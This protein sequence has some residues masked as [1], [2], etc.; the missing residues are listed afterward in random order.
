MPKPISK[1]AKLNPQDVLN[2][3]AEYTNLQY[4]AMNK[5]GTWY[6]FTKQPANLT[7]SQGWYSP[8]SNIKLKSDLFISAKDWAKSLLATGQNSIKEYK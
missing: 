5:D 3:L 2:D 6:A 7:N 1:Q 4:I 8:N